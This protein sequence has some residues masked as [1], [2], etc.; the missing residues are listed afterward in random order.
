MT[1]EDQVEDIIAE[2]TISVVDAYN[3]GFK[4]GVEKQTIVNDKLANPRIILM[5]F[6]EFVKKFK[7]VMYDEQKMFS[8]EDYIIT[9][10]SLISNFLMR[11]D[12]EEKD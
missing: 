10:D 12:Y 3:R 2:A 1:T 11:T 9:D 6:L 4:H 8:T 7:L 5:D